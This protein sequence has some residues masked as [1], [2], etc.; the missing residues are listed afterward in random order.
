MSLGKMGLAGVKH[1]KILSP[2]ALVLVL[3]K[4]VRI[5]VLFKN[6]YRS[7]ICRFFFL[8]RLFVQR[9]KRG[10]RMF[11]TNVLTFL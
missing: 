4:K 7:A 3:L 10:E 1:G 2:D 11:M 5:K 8:T 9:V 6:R